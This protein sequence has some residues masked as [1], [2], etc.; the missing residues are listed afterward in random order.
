MKSDL[1]IAIKH[2]VSERKLPQEV[3]LETIKAALVAAYKKTPEGLG[4]NVS[5][6]LDPVSGKARVFAEKEVVEEVK[7]PRVQISLAE[8]L[9]MDEEALVGDRIKI[10]V[11][12]RD[13]GRIPAQTA[14][15]V[16][17]QRIRE[18]ER[19]HLYRTYAEQRGEIVNATVQNLGPD[20]TFNLGDVEAILPRE[21]RMATDRYRPNQRL[22][23]YI[24]NVDK[25]NKG[26]LITVSRRHP[27][28]LRR[29]LELEVPEISNGSVEIKAI[30]RE[31]GSRSKVAVVS[32]QEGIDPVGACVGVRGVRIQALVNEL[33]GEKID[34]VEWNPNPA[35]FIANA[36]SPASVINVTLEET[37]AGKTANVVVPDRQLSLA[38]G[39]AGQNARLAAKLTGWRIDIK[40]ESEALEETK[41]RAEQEAALAAARAL[42][43]E[44][45]EAARAEAEEA[46]APEEVE[47]EVAAEEVPVVEAEPEVEEVAPA[48]PEAEAEEVV[49]PEAEAEAEEVVAA[50]P[51]AE[52][53]VA[54]EPEAEEV[55]VAEPEAEEVELFPSPERYEIDEEWVAEEEE[56]GLSKE[57][58]KK[59]QRK[60]RLIYDEELGEVV[61]KRIRKPGRRQRG[62]EEEAEY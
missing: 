40:N 54:A 26:P 14:K 20:V 57:D 39:K 50:E 3:V 9:K 55:V 62:W 24:L 35:R 7:D 21:E 18:A 60:K 10:D 47:P 15:Q 13:F 23:V 28:M 52:E 61:A 29:L 32:R 58:R 17:L 37:E 19:D 53:V 42:L 34:V 22:R 30:A 48:E 2:V 43:A 6:E 59:K 31:A 36:L 33:G 41:R 56:E 27:L 1:L 45:E 49:L 5:A 11:T 4:Q 25:G 44:A 12:P 46:E 16:I 51:E 38:I 8:A